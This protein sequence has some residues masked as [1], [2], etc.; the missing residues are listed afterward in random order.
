MPSPSC[1]GSNLID[2]ICDHAGGRKIKSAAT[3]TIYP[4]QYYTDFGGGSGNQFKH[5]FIG[6]ERIL[7]K[8]SR[9]AP[10]R[11]H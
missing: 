8:K 11:E 7:T 1:T 6:S 10:D 5:I 2:F 4:N 3:P 9:I